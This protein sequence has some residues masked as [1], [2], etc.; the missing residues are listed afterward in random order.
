MKKLLEIPKFENE[1]EEREFWDSHSF[2]D[3]IDSKSWKRG[4]SDAVLRVLAELSPEV[5]RLS[6]EKRL[7]IEEMVR[8]LV[9]AGLKLQ[10]P[11]PGA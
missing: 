6:R 8:Q 5:E 1:D 9:A 2:T 10:R 4:S 11:Q 7:S 3:Y